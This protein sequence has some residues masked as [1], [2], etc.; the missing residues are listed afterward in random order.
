MRST[1]WAA[2][3][4][5]GTGQQVSEFPRSWSSPA[6]TRRGLTP[7]PIATRS[8]CCASGSAPSC[9]R[10][11]RA[12]GIPSEATPIFAVVADP[13][14]LVQNRRDLDRAELDGFREWDGIAELGK[15]LSALPAQR[16]DLRMAAGVRFAAF[17]VSRA[18]SSLSG[19]RVD[20]ELAREALQVSVEK[21]ALAAMRLAAMTRSARA[22]LDGLVQEVVLGAVR[23]ASPDLET[24]QGLLQGRLKDVLIRW[25]EQETRALADHLAEVQ[26][27][28]DVTSRSPSF[29][30][31]EEMFAVRG[32]VPPPTAARARRFF[33]VLHRYGPKGAD[34]LESIAEA[35]LGMPLKKAAEHLQKLKDGGGDF[36]A[37]A[38]SAKRAAQKFATPEDADKARDWVKYAG[39][40]VAAV[41]V[42]AEAAG[43]AA[44]IAADVDSKA[45]A[46]QRTERRTR[47]RETLD[48]LSVT[49]ADSVWADWWEMASPAVGLV[50]EAEK[51]ARALD[52]RLAAE[53]ATLDEHLSRLNAVGA[54]QPLV[55]V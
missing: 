17:A 6:W 24:L 35:R 4:S 10:Y 21:H 51:A 47:V 2:G 11:S 48:E 19:L 33:E 52:A 34:V 46:Q 54:A 42:I 40:L 12:A 36:A 38:K 26:L 53:I 45:L 49:V 8:K 15:A 1:C 37:Y 44:Q 31:L 5:R 29:R 39:P 9:A 20:R 22:R 41:P 32:V 25:F 16:D 55:P 30:G 28:L 23:R 13:F 50:A 43:L 27:G 14:Q 18:V 7:R 3:I